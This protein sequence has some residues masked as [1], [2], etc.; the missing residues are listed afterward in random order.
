MD[1]GAP[2]HRQAGGRG[3]DDR[4]PRR[5]RMGRHPRQGLPRHRQERALRAL[6]DPRTTT[7]LVRRALAKARPRSATSWSP[8]AGHLGRLGVPRG[9]RPSRRRNRRT[10][11][12]AGRVRRT[13]RWTSSTRALAARQTGLL[14]RRHPAPRP[15]RCRGAARAATHARQ[16]A[17][18]RERREH[19]RRSA[20]RPDR[21]VVDAG[22]GRRLALRVYGRRGATAACPSP[23]RPPMDEPVSEVTVELRRGKTLHARSAPLN[24]GRKVRRVLLRRHGDER[25]PRGAYSLSSAAAARCSNGAPCVFAERSTLVIAV[26]TAAVALAVAVAGVGSRHAAAPAE[27]GARRQRLPPRRLARELGRQRRGC[28]VRL[29]AGQAAAGQGAAR[30]HHARLLRVLRLR[31]DVRADPPHGAEGQHRHLPALA[32]RRRG[33]LPRAVRHRALHDARR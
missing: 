2:R 21:F 27:V 18:T 24:A 20:A 6:D 30:D 10:D 13:A 11:L 22:K 19:A 28:L 3:R 1:R 29:R 16:R 23:S 32:D 14:R 25:F 15:R 26:L 17:P 5:H 8:R 12:P 33:S 9:R 7:K 31:P 4:A